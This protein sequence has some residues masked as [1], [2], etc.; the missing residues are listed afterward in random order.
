[1]NGNDEFTPEDMKE[2]TVPQLKFL[3]ASAE[4]ALLL[5]AIDN[6]APHRSRRELHEY[7]ADI[8]TYNEE[9]E[10]RDCIRLSTD[11]LNIR[12]QNEEKNT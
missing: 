7:V 3:K 12:N 2:L 6:P 8:A 1:M 9:R 4:A 10:I 5:C 11:E